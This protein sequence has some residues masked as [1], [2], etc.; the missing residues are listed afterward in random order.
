MAC[1]PASE[2]NVVIFSF[3]LIRRRQSQR[4]S[5]VR[6][7]QTERQGRRKRDGGVQIEGGGEQDL[8]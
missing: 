6:H 5:G 1:F 8:P 2:E 3:F 7:T 4:K